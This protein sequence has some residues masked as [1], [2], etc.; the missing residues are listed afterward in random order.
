MAYEYTE[1]AEWPTI[2]PVVRKPY[3]GRVAY[4]YTEQAECPTN[5]PNFYFHSKTDREDLRRVLFILDII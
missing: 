5:I 4:E 3:T 1:Q 2:T